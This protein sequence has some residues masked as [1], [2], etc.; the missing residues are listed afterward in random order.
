MVFHFYFFRAHTGKKPLFPLNP[1]SS[2]SRSN[3]ITSPLTEKFILPSF[4][5]RK[6]TLLLLLSKKFW[7]YIAFRFGPF[8]RKSFKSGSRRSSP[9]GPP[10]KSDFNTKFQLI[11][12]MFEK[13]MLARWLCEWPQAIFLLWDQTHADGHLAD[14][15]TAMAKTSGRKAHKDFFR[16]SLK[17]TCQF[18]F[19]LWPNK[20][21]TCY[22]AT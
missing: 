8:K 3:P 12:N 2:R 15:H 19:T 5:L 7:L 11:W 10:V 22:N 1:E 6:I 14:K 9:R 4:P 16:V 21:V 20:L 17:A 13:Y 18:K